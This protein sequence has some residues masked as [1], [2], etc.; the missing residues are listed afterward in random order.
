MYFYYDMMLI[1]TG[2]FAYYGRTRRISLYMATY[3]NTKNCVHWG[4][5]NP[6]AVAPVPIFDAKW[7]VWCG[8]TATFVLGP[9]FFDEMTPTGPAICSVTGSRYAAIV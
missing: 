4:E 2:N 1:T 7:T 3:I 6:H 9:F 5:T 8:V